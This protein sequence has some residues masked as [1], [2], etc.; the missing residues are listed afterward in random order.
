M[1]VVRNR[2]GKENIRRTEEDLRLA[3]SVQLPCPHSALAYRTLNE[4]VQQWQA[5]APPLLRQKHGK[6]SYTQPD[7]MR[8]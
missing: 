6:I 7:E 2:P 3:A 4:F 5:V 1:A 8:G